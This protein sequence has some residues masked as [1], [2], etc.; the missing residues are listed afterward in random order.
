MLSSFNNMLYF[1]IVITLT[2][3]FDT[4][5]TTSTLSTDSLEN[6]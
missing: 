5:H 4:K 6:I 2:S 3:N 1:Y